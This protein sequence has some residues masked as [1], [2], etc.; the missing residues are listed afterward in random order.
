[1]RRRG[2][3]RRRWRRTMPPLPARHR[4]VGRLPTAGGSLPP[5]TRTPRRPQWTS[6]RGRPRTRRT[7]ERERSQAWSHHRR[8]P[9]RRSRELRL[10][11]PR[12]RTAGAAADRR[13][14]SQDTWEEEGSQGQGTSRSSSS[15]SSKRY[16][17]LTAAPARALCLPDAGRGRAATAATAWIAHGGA[18]QRQGHGKSALRCHIVR[19]ALSSLAQD[20]RSAAD[21]SS[22]PLRSAQLSTRPL[23][24]AGGAYRPRGKGT[25]RS[26]G[27]RQGGTERAKEQEHG[28]WDDA[29]GSSRPCRAEECGEELCG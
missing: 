4:C 18:R 10:R 20:G 23:P 21:V 26:W 7:G 28:R 14:T 6:P 16:A 12:P 3:K 27:T 13:T 19:A 1:M 2:R 8:R 17:V 22:A 29:S 9:R 5:R 25:P 15:S 11:L 24:Q